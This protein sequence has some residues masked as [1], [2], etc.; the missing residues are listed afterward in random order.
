MVYQDMD[1]RYWLNDNA[2]VHTE[3][4]RRAA[5]HALINN[6]RHAFE[7]ACAGRDMM[8]YLLPMDKTHCIGRSYAQLT[9]AN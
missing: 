8:L 4:W 1:Q 9:M 5:A 2:L 3:P 6:D 7:A